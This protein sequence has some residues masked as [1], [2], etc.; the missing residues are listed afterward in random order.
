[1]DASAIRVWQV[2]LGL[3]GQVD[4]ELLRNHPPL[5]VQKPLD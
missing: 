5:W 3:I 2:G 4:F 1:M